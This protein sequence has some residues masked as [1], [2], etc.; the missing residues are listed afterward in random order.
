VQGPQGNSASSRSLQRTFGASPAPCPA[1]T[2]S[3]RS[4]PSCSFLPMSAPVGTVRK[5]QQLQRA[6]ACVGVG[7]VAPNQPRVA[8]WAPHHGPPH[9]REL[10]A[11]ILQLSHRAKAFSS[12]S[13]NQ[14]SFRAPTGSRAPEP[15]ART[16]ASACAALSAPRQPPVWKL[17]ARPPAMHRLAAGCVR[18][19]ASER[20]ERGSQL[21]GRLAAAWATRQTAAS[22]G[23]ELQ[24]RQRKRRRRRGQ[25]EEGAGGAGSSRGH[26]VTVSG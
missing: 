7:A 25:V 20:G 13:L 22:R 5:T 21:H 1:R 15:G 9:T 4:L 24:A 26:G 8:G 16:P 18:A 11:C 12:R 23:C 14:R 19:R 17:G 2:L 10:G 6:A 3:Q